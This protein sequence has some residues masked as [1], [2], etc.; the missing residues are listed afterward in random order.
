MK[1]MVLMLRKN[2]TLEEEVNFS[3]D[4]AFCYFGRFPRFLGCTSGYQNVHDQQL[5]MLSESFYLVI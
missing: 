5:I 1:L 3:A 2:L 4:T